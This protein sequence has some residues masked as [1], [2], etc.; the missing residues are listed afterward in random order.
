VSGKKSDF[1]KGKNRREILR[2][3]ERFQEGMK[4]KRIDSSLQLDK[5]FLHYKINSTW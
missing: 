4:M 3:K 1:E 2:K 5:F